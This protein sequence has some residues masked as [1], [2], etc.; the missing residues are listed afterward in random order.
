[1]RELLAEKYRPKTIDDYIFQNPL[2][3]KTVQSWVK[4]KTIPNVMMVGSQGLGKTTLARI[5]RNELG[6]SDADFKVMN[7][8]ADTGISAIRDELIPWMKKAPLGQFKIVHLEEM[9]RLS[10]HAFDSLKQLTEEFSD[11]IRFIATAN[12]ISRI[13]VTLISRF[14][15]LDLDGIN[16]DA[17]MERVVDI[18]EREEIFAENDDLDVVK[19]HV[20]LFY[21]DFRKILNSIEQSSPLDDNGNGF[22]TLYPPVEASHTSEEL[23]NWEALCA[24]E[25]LDPVNLLGLTHLVDDANYDWF[26]EKL[27]ERSHFYE[28]PAVAVIKI[29]KYLDMATRTANQQIIL[30]ACLYDLFFME[31]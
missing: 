23:D 24:E 13:P 21:P 12:T 18:L 14:T 26:Y 4:Q 11:Y 28:D 22:R 2:N 6:V 15:M 7:C 19:A 30:D 29:A 27:Y 10:K 25:S 17:I 8:S 20:D 9:D 5:L 31:S 3:K 1:M 16:K